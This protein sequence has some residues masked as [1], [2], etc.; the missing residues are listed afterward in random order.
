MAP[1]PSVHKDC[2]H[3]STKAARDAC[4]MQ[5]EEYRAQERKRKQEWRT[6]LGEDE[7]GAK[8]AQRQK[9]LESLTEDEREAKRVRRREWDKVNRPDRN[10]IRRRLIAS[11]A[12]QE[13]VDLRVVFDCD[14]GIC[15]L[16]D[17]PVEWLTRDDAGYFKWGPSRDHVIP[18]QGEDAQGDHT[19]M[20]V[21][22]AHK[23][24]NSSK[25]NRPWTPAKRKAARARYRRDHAQAA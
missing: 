13:P 11:E 8:R 24:C 19:Y 12:E 18:L 14:G 17:Y 1:K 16:C 5:S 2:D 22:L 3:P 25:A 4:R 15:H 23:S 10:L 9:W 21:R 6:T 20:N 7:R